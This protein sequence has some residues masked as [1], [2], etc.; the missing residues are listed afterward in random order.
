MLLS[1]SDLSDFNSSESTPTKGIVGVIS[2]L[3]FWGNFSK[4]KKIIGEISGY[5]VWSHI[6]RIAMKCYFMIKVVNVFVER[7]V[8]F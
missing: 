6:R 3:S 2:S 8:V 5:F 1:V 7:Q 4:L